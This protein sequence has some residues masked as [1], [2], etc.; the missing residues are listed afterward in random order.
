MNTPGSPKPGSD[1]PVRTMMRLI[2]A[3]AAP[4]VIYVLVWELFAGAV[5]PNVAPAGQWFAIN[6]ANALIPCLGVL[7]SVFLAGVKIGRYLGGGV[8]M[9]FF[10]YS[11]LVSGTAFGWL[12]IALTLGGVAL[13]W[14]LAR[15]TPRLSPD[16]DGLI[17]S[18]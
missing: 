11:Y 6:L 9:L 3:F 4:V 17:G 15:V 1:E 10:L 12:P 16:L 13:A 7:G 14:A 18:A 2:G 8:M 5:L